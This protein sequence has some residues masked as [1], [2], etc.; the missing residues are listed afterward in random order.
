MKVIDGKPYRELR[1]PE[2]HCL[3]CYEYIFSGRVALDKCPKCGKASTLTFKHT[4]TT[5]NQNIIDDD[6][7]VH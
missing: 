7:V 1:C 4:K 2:C 6:F 5:E 3:I